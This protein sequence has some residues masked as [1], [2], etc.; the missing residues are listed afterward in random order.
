MLAGGQSSTE[1][2]G[3]TPVRMVVIETDGTYEQADSLKVAYEGAPATGLDVFRHSVDAVLEH[4]GLAARTAW[5]RGPVRLLQA[6][7]GRDRLRR[8]HV[9]SSLQVGICIRQSIC[10]LLA[11]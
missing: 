10:L 6:V 11:T 5:N 9:R 4:P 3:L 2:L 8:R 1:A 7:P